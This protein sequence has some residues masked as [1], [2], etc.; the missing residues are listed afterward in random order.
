MKWLFNVFSHIK[1]FFKL[2]RLG[3]H[4]IQGFIIIFSNRVLSG[5]RW[6]YSDKGNKVVQRWMWQGS[7]IL[8][9]NIQLSGTAYSHSAVLVANHISWLD[10]VAIAAT[11]PVT[12]V[13]KNDLQRWPLV[14]SLAGATGT[15][16]IQRGSL[17]AMHKSIRRLAQIT[18][19]GCKTA[20]FPEGT[21]TTGETVKKFN[22]GLFES[23]NN[24]GCPVQP[25]AIS[26]FYRGKP[27]L[28]IAPY[29]DD[30]HFMVH[31]WNVFRAGQL[32]VQLDYLDEIPAN[33]LS[34]QELAITSRARI[35]EV[36]ETS[37]MINQDYPLPA[38]DMAYAVSH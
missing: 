35:V 6:Y 17:F 14:G 25:V 21:T 22:S 18:N 32:H 20:F 7:R 31:L 5:P 15:V 29:V 38:D 16:F 8:G 13:S 28:S 26:Y 11:A 12:F 2:T 27:D 23:A 37:Q 10:I 34:R 3:I 9:L 1:A 19:A 36:L 24:S 30:D 4:F 33:T